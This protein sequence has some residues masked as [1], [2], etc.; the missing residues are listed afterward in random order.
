MIFARFGCLEAEGVVLAHT[1]RLSHRTIKKGKSL[2]SDDLIDIQNAGID[3]VAGARLEAGDINEDQAAISVA[4]ALAGANLTV[5]KPLGGRCNLYARRQGVVVIDRARIDAINLTDGAIS[6]ATLPEHAEA[7][8]EQA[9]ASIKVIPFA[10]S[11]PLVDQCVEL[12]SGGGT[13]ESD[14][15]AVSLKPYKP[16]PVA[17]ILTEATGL[18]ASVLD[19]TREVTQARLQSMGSQVVFEQRCSH[20]IEDVSQALKRALV[21]ECELILICGAT[22]TVDTGD[23]VP[24]AIVREGGKVDH[25][26]MPVEPGNMLLL[27][28]H[29]SCTIVNLP[30]CSRSPK[31]N[32]LDW[33]LQRIL[34]G[35]PVG[36]RDIQMMGVGGL[37][38]DIPMIERIKSERIKK[39][40]RQKQV[41]GDIVAP[42]KDGRRGNPVLWARRYFSAMK[43]LTGDMGARGLLKEHAGNVWDV[44]ISDDDIFADI[45]TPEALAEVK[46]ELKNGQ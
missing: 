44:P 21:S 27:A 46:A 31:L 30:G 6:V 33:V 20:S 17:L 34:A 5:G 12:A 15:L 42:F 13:E 29:G 16:V 3:Y 22:V 43:A 35:I 10:V 23:V 39:Q 40:R 36:R 7:A 9:V 41:S 18:K 26:G 24:S 45:D 37:I 38:K 19:S 2:T 11:Q 25:F 14:N 1:L 32:G 28:H 4:N 8:A